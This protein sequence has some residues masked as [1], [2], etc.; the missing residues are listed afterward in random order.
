[1]DMK[2]SFKKRKTPKRGYILALFFLTVIALLVFLWYEGIIIPN[3]S[4]ANEYPVKGVDVSAYQGD[5]DWDHLQRQGLS[6]AFI[7]AT[8]GSSFVDRY[9]KKNW[10]YANNTPLRMG[11]YHFFSYDSG[12][13]T[14]AEN[15]IKTVPIDESALPPVIDVEFYGDKEKNL[16]DR[17]DVVRELTVMIDLLEEHYGKRVILYTTN[18]A[19]D[20]FIK[21]EFQQCD[22]WIRD[23]F[24]P[25]SLP[26][27]RE[28]TFWQYTDREKLEGYNGE[29]KFI[30]V[31]VFSGSKQEF[32]D[33]GYKK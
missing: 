27:N 30:D 19:Y 20:L 3:A 8:E 15:F 4:R 31:N 24:Q 2:Y 14:Q 1:M 32:A 29:E 17:A 33:Y 28:W 18:K 10:E 13:D 7:K 11:A 6:F 26:D 5:I 25:P 22:I 12:G 21:D 9:F 16:P 23:V